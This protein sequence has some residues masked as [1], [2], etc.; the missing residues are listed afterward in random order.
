M[1]TESYKKIIDVIDNCIETS[2]DEN[3][4]SLYYAIRYFTVKQIDTP[5]IVKKIGPLVIHPH[6]WV[7]ESARD[8]IA[9]CLD[10]N[11]PTRIFFLFREIFAPPFPL[12]PKDMTDNILLPEPLLES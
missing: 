4:F 8:Y 2:L 11:P 3:G 12:Q 1:G 7:R 10:K 6:V 5:M 9:M